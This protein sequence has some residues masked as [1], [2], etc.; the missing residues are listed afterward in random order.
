M[1]L[2]TGVQNLNS[3]EMPLNLYQRTYQ[4]SLGEGAHP[5]RGP[6]VP[7]FSPVQVLDSGCSP[8]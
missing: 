6:R 4:E 7:A 2:D 5:T 3:G 1:A 8:V